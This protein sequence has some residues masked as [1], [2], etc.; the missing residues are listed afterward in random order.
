M[1]ISPLA[2]SPA[3]PTILVNVPRLIRAYYTEEPDPSVPAQR[4]GFGTSGH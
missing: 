1:K 2:G 4:V 3:P